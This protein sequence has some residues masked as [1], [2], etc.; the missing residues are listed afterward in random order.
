MV[1]GVAGG[2][3]VKR[4]NRAYRRWASQPSLLPQPFSNA[5]REGGERERALSQP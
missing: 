2:Q 4:V 5:G 3:A 1:V